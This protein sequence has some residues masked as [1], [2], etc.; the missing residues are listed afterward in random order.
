MDPKLQ[1]R[2]DAANELV[3]EIAA[4]FGRVRFRVT[5][6]SMMPSVWPDD[7]VEI[8]RCDPADLEPAQIV[9]YRRMG[10]LVVH[11]IIR[12]EP[13]F[14]VTRGDA[15][16]DE[17]SPIRKADVLGRVVRIQRRGRLLYPKRSRLLRTC[18]AIFRRSDF[19]LGMMLRVGR[20][21]RQYRSKEL[22]W[23]N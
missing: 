2:S 5:G 14:L 16:S 11:R 13:D 6:A 7:I 18:S 3:V 15:V 12:V 8:R 4:K 23:S 19:C 22:S 20:I 17:D 10:R 1:A 9:L 21:V